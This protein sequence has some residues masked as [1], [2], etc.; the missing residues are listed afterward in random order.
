[1]IINQYKIYN[2]K[3]KKYNKKLKTNKMKKHSRKQNYKITITYQTPKRSYHVTLDT[4]NKKHQ[5]PIYY[6]TTTHNNHRKT[7][8]HQK[9]RWK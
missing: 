5:E 7:N 2:N 1:M 8:K 4:G 6:E 3:M 9:T